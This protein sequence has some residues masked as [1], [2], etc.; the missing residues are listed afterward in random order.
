MALVGESSTPRRGERLEDPPARECA[1]RTSPFSDAAVVVEG[2]AQDVDHS[3]G[4]APEYR[5]DSIAIL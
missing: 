2:D 5:A 3:G 1:D 4:E